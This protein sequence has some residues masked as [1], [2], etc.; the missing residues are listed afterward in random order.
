MR[1]VLPVPGGPCRMTWPLRRRLPTSRVN[2]AADESS[3]RPTS[4]AVAA[5]AAS[6]T[7]LGSRCASMPSTRAALLPSRARGASRATPSAATMARAP[8]S[9]AAMRVR[10]TV[11]VSS[12]APSP[13]ARRMLATAPSASAMRRADGAWSRD[14]TSSA[15][16]TWRPLP[17]I[18]RA[19]STASTAPNLRSACRADVLHAATLAMATHAALASHVSFALHASM[20]ALTSARRVSQPATWQAATTAARSRREQRHAAS[21]PSPDASGSTSMPPIPV[22]ALARM[23]LSASVFAASTLSLVMAAVAP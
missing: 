14:S 1:C 15:S 16:A 3:V 12:S 19:P 23:R 13:L 9:V 18:M 5:V 20:A 11:S 8:L 7:P 2:A 6:S 17:S 10:M 22:A 21:S 4:E